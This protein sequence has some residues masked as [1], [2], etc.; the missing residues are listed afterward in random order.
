MAVSKVS[1]SFDS[2]LWTLV[3]RVFVPDRQDFFG[4]ISSHESCDL[5]AVFA[6]CAQRPKRITT[7]VGVEDGQ[8]VDWLGIL[9]AL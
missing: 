4:E 6:G 5:A 3:V 2:K 9:D 7:A 1:R 8:Q